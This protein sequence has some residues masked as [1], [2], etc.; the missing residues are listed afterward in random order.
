[1]AL[2]LTAALTLLIA[3]STQAFA[4]GNGSN[5]SQNIRTNNG[6]VVQLN[7]QQNLQKAAA[8]S[9]LDERGWMRVLTPANDP[10]PSDY[11]NAPNQVGLSQ[12]PPKDLKIFY[13]SNLAYC[14]YDHCNIVVAEVGKENV[15]LISAQRIKKGIVLS[16]RI[17]DKDGNIVAK[18]EDDRPYINRNFV[19]DFNRP[20][21]HSLWIKDNH[22][23]EVLNVRLLNPTSLR[24]EGV[25]NLPYDPSLSAPIR[26]Y[27]TI[28][29]DALTF[30]PQGPS[31]TGDC[32]GVG[33]AIIGA[34][35]FGYRSHP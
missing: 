15:P 7:V 33:S 6:V 35:A 16:A 20:D 31:Y 25:F 30:E 19:S 22:D 18:I 11:C 24:I 9:M 8:A 32:S 4:Q 5:H 21:E 26:Q 34:I 17:Y 2:L 1:M 27:I 29:K 23:T 12:I 13:G 28:S 10:T 14:S 3:M